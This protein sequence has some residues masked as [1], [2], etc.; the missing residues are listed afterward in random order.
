M[1]YYTRK[2][3]QTEINNDRFLRLLSYYLN[4]ADTCVAK[5]EF[6]AVK[7]AGVSDEMAFAL[8]LGIHLGLDDEGRDRDFFFDYF[9]E[10]IKALEVK[11]YYKDEYFKIV[12]FSGEKD[13]A[14]EL[15]NKSYKPFQG[16]VRDDFRYFEDGRVVPQIGFFKKTFTYPAVL[17]NG[18]EWMTLLPNEINSQ[19]KYIEAA[20]G[21]VLTY[22][23]GLGYYAFCVAKK[24]SVQSVTV[25]EKNSTVINLFKKHILPCFPARVSEK[26]IITEADAF[27]Y[28]R[29]L[30]DGRYDYIYA[31]IWRDV[32]DGKDLYL[33]FKSMEHFCP[34]AKYGYWIEDTI[35]YYL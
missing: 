19:K 3:E 34:S 13:G 21:K 1:D 12:K 6:N 9:M 17:E 25:V 8:V 24:P 5:N 16:F 10:S 27:D 32:S 11:D 28:Q 29:G 18:T 30:T 2:R 23:L 22:G 35:K 15:T 14:V 33:K 7:G 20:S 26:I 4:D 31:D